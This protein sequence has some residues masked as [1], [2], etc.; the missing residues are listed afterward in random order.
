MKNIR[1]SLL[2]TVLILLFSAGVQALTP[3]QQESQ[4]QQPGHRGEGMR[5]GFGMGNGIVGTVKTV[6]AD[7]FVIKSD[8]GPEYTIHFSANTRILRQNA[9]PNMDGTNRIGPGGIPPQAIHASEI[10]VGDVITAG[11][12]VDAQAK[13]VGA[14][15][16]LQMNPEMV[17]FMRD[18]KANYGKTWL[19]GKITAINDVTVK[20]DSQSDHLSHTFTADENTSF[21]K[22]REPVTLGDLQVGEMVEVE[23]SIK[24]GVFLATSVRAMGR[25]QG[26]PPSLPRGDQPPPK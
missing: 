3:I 16:I 11:G 23:G 21:R 2:V 9:R 17:K 15:F 20:I 25:L 6:S 18:R 24:N 7:H 13:S 22:G 4:N 8:E 14:I 1:L 19:A 12:E 5:G 26:P 10:K